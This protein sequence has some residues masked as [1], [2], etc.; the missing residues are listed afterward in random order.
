[1]TYLIYLFFVSQVSPS[2]KTFAYV[3]I[4]NV[5]EVVIEKFLIDFQGREVVSC[6]DFD[7]KIF[8]NKSSLDYLLRGTH[9]VEHFTL[10]CRKIVR[11]SPSVHRC[12]PIVSKGFSLFPKRHN[13]G[14]VIL[15][16]FV[17]RCDGCIHP[18]N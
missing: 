14:I 11:I 16:N 4:F 15:I 17:E 3:H 12:C 10:R 7:D 2:D 18:E 8:G 1:M 9:L 13:V 5:I 6:F